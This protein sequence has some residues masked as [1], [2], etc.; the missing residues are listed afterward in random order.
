M[1]RHGHSGSWPWKNSYPYLYVG[2]R[3]IFLYHQTQNCIS[4]K[5]T[6]IRYYIWSN[7]TYILERVYLL[8]QLTHAMFY[9]VKL[10]ILAFRFYLSDLWLGVRYHCTCSPCDWHENC[11]ASMFQGD[12]NMKIAHKWI[13]NNWNSMIS[14]IIY[15]YH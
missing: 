9:F 4:S 7:K 2:N 13:I 1:P 14:R 6:K 12:T 3:L 15:L 11:S 5:L 10:R 8:R